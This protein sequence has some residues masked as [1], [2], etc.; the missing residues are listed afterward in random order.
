MNLSD[1]CIDFLA[2]AAY[3]NANRTPHTSYASDVP[4]G[5][6]FLYRKEVFGCSLKLLRPMKSK[7]H[8]SIQKDFL[9]KLKYML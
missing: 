4:H 3:H 8:L 2:H 6:T 5:E 7:F 1:F 9:S